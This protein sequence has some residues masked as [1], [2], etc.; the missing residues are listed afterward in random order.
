MP[1]V[2][3]VLSPAVELK[4][5][6]A[7]V[8]RLGNESVNGAAAE[9]ERNVVDKGVILRGNVLLRAEPFENFARLR[10][11]QRKL[12]PLAALVA[13]VHVAKQMALDPRGVLVAVAR[14]DD[15]PVVVGGTAVNDEIV[16]NA[17][18]VVA[19]HGVLDVAVL[20]GGDVRGDELLHVCD[21]VGALEPQLAHVRHVKESR[22]LPH[23]HVLG[24]HTG[25]V[26]HGHQK[27]AEL[28]DLSARVHMGLIQG[29]F[30]FH[31]LFPP[32]LSFLNDSIKM[33]KIWHR[34]KAQSPPWNFVPPFYDLRVSLTQHIA[35]CRL[36]LRRAASRT[37]RSVVRVRSFC[38]RASA[39]PFGAA[40]DIPRSLP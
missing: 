12:S 10:P 2:N 6:F 30:P 37:F 28:N 15:Q 34:K 35:S 3:G 11:L 25:G 23:G 8:A 36:H 39:F 7:G 22:L 13:V 1:E 32:L 33:I 19:E 29:C 24:E 26:L 38:L 4:A 21:R 40:A 14:I 16:N 9:V 18:R 20:H 27:A 31:K 5:V 17:A